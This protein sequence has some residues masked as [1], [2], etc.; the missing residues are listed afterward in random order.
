MDFI[1]SDTEDKWPE[2]PDAEKRAYLTK[3]GMTVT[4]PDGRVWW[5][6]KPGWNVT[7]GNPKSETEALWIAYDLVFDPPPTSEERQ[8]FE[9]ALRS[10]I[11]QKRTEQWERQQELMKQRL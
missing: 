3:R 6:Q 10:E 11:R 5:L 2:V 8:E 1:E 4:K 9:N 7:L